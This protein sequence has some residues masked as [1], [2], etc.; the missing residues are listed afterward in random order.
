MR[1]VSKVAARL[2]IAGLT[3][4]PHARSTR[5]W[6]SLPTE[7]LRAL[8]ASRG[9]DPPL[10]VDPVE[11]GPGQGG[12]AGG[13]GHVAELGAVRLA[14]RQAPVEEPLERGILLRVS[15]LLVQQEPAE[16]H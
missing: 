9:P 7:R 8:R 16:R 12:D 2:T 14:E 5:A 15:R 4:P 6:R 1:F 3:R 13:Q 11:R 10:L